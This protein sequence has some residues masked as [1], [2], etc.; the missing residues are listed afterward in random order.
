MMQ[1]TDTLSGSVDDAEDDQL[2]PAEWPDVL[3]VEDV[4]KL[5][6]LD[7]KTIYASVRAGEIPGVRRIGRTIRFHR[8]TVLGWLRQGS[9]SRSPRRRG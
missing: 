5:L 8:D 9:G 7:R 3:T 1:P 4:T 6:R 2:E